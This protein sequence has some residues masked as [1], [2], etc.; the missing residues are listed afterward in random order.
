M[1]CDQRSLPVDLD[2]RVV[3][4]VDDDRP[5]DLVPELLAVL[6]PDQHEVEDDRGEE[7]QRPERSIDDQPLADHLT[8]H[9][10][11]VGGPLPRVLFH[12]LHLEQLLSWRLRR[13]PDDQRP[14]EPADEERDDRQ[15]SVQQIAPEAPTHAAELNPLRH[16]RAARRRRRVPSRRRDGRA[17]RRRR[18]R[19]RRGQLAH[20]RAPLRETGPAAN[21]AGAK[22]R[23]S[24]GWR[25]KPVGKTVPDVATTVMSFPTPRSER[26]RTLPAARRVGKGCHGP[27]AACPPKSGSGYG[28]AWRD[29]TPVMLA[30]RGRRASA[31]AW[32]FTYRFRKS[33]V[34]RSTTTS[35][36]FV[37]PPKALPW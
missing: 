30:S 19:R 26:S 8:Q 10:R 4:V 6:V 28:T 31:P 33:V 22:P 23:G 18:R 15:H 3:G 32:P 11:P 29:D 37:P 24:S 16:R 9:N 1:Q 7:A 36:G 2:E 27:T 13:V 12:R 20:E 21:T 5:R 14:D 25:R 17:T 35:A 34:V